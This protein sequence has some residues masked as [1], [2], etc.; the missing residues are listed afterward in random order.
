MLTMK[1]S[2]TFKNGGFEAIINRAYISAGICLE[3]K[4][5]VTN[6]SVQKNTCGSHK[7]L[8][9]NKGTKHEQKYRDTS[10]GEEAATTR[11]W[12]FGL[13]FGN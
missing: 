11:L 8:A 5:S 2:R 12:I 3:T 1:P 6:G 10:K 9:V 13:R 7:E 4:S